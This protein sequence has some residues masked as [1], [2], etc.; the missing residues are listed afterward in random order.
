MESVTTTTRL[1]RA[2]KELLAALAK[3]NSRS[4]TKE[5]SQIIRDAAKR[6]GFVL[7]EFGVRGKVAK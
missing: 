6:Q 1:C 5:L 7:A 2:D 4:Q 3:L